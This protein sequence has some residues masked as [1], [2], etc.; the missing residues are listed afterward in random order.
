MNLL[1]GVEAMARDLAADGRTTPVRT[2]EGAH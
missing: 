1:I 2:P